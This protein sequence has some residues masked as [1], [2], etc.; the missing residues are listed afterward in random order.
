MQVNKNIH[1]SPMMSA[2]TM[3]NVLRG[4]S[5]AFIP[6]TAMLPAALHVSFATTACTMFLQMSATNSRLI[7]RLV[8][9]PDVW[10]VPLPSDVS[11]VPRGC[12][13]VCRRS[14]AAHTRSAPP[15]PP[16]RPRVH[17]AQRASY[18]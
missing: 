16:A 12:V 3:R 11:P 6:L 14:C 1:D 4:M 18:G 10:P 5:V 2:K 13:C 15:A 8:G 17:S 9:L 7:R